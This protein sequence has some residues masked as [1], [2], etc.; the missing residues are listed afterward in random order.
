V[1]GTVR[2]VVWEDGEGD[3]ASYPIQGN[4][5]DAVVFGSCGAKIGSLSCASWLMS[6]SLRSNTAI[7]KFVSFMLI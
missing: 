2:T 6:G 3:L 7:P 1:Y 4:E 5:E